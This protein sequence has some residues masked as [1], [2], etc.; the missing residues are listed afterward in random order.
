MVGRIAGIAGRVLVA[1]GVLLLLFT[2]YQV[3]GTWLLEAHTQ[4]NL[5]SQL[6][7]ELP[8]G[9][10]TRARRIAAGPP[11][12]P[13]TVAGPPQVAPTTTTPATGSPVGIIDIP[14]IGLDQVVVEGVQTADLRDG[15]GHYP[16]TPLPGQA[17]NAAI[18][19]H[20]TTYGHPFYDLNAVQPG[21]RVVVTTPQ[22]IFVYAA[23]AQSVVAPTDVSVV[24]P[25]AGAEL[26]LTTCNP[27][28]SASTRLVLHATLV[29]SSLFGAVRPATGPAE[30]H[31][32]RSSRPATRRRV[33]AAA[34]LA[35]GASGSWLPALLWGL[36]AAALAV[37]V[38]VAARRTARAWL[39]YLCGAVA[40]L[41]VLFFFFSAVTP[42]LPAS[43]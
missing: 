18:A 40:L 15:P 10:V 43:V 29:S 5:R 28:Y 1:G 41:V 11:V 35:G 22:G 2:A 42:L 39:V 31:R 34:G 33:D 3:W 8:A 9:A 14:S 37:A 6:A 13:R 30:A 17:G 12:E 26:T 25:T 16:K 19:G 24:G 21:A 38:L 7:H 4:S 23:G 27:R 20:R 36:A 32:A